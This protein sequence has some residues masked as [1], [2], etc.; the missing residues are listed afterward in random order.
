M[1][2][3]TGFA[4]A[5]VNLTLH[6]TGQRPDGYHLVDSLVVFADFGDHLSCVEGP[7]MQLSITGPFAKGVPTD[8]RNLVWRAAKL[9]RWTGHIT[10]EKNLPHGAGIGGGSADAAALLRGL[11]GEDV[12]RGVGLEKTLGL[13]ADV[14]VC[15]SATAQR[16]QGIGGDLTPVLSV[17]SLHIVLVNPGLHLSTPAVFAAL[18]SRENPAMGEI[19]KTRSFKDLMAWLRAQRNDLQEAATDMQP[20]I[21]GVLAALRDSDLVRMSGSGSTCFGIYADA[22]HASAAAK[23]IARAHPDWWVV[24]TKTLGAT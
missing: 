16:V 21:R 9:A 19:P 13:G 7:E 12:S 10:L 4:P 24:G 3:K 18:R 5:K 1:T 15:M 20:A 6:V 14:A 8:E 22:G 17:P 11:Y 23:R 2:A